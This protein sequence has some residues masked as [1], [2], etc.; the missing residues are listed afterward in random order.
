VVIL[1]SETFRGPMSGTGEESNGG[2]SDHV[3]ETIFRIIELSIEKSFRFWTDSSRSQALEEMERYRIIGD[4][5]CCPEPKDIRR[6][7]AV[8]SKI[9]FL[10]TII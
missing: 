5:K 2:P 9:I 8:D 1:L 4:S 10:L 6:S 7:L 3:A